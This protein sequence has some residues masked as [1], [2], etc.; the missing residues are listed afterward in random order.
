MRLTF[1]SD[2]EAMDSARRTISGKIL[3]FGN[4]V[5]HTNVGKVVFEDESEIGRAHV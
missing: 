3:P 4:E 2:I 1:S 5:G